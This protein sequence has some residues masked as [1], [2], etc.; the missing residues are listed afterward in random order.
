[1]QS[2]VDQSNIQHTFLLLLLLL[3]A[4]KAAYFST[5]AEVHY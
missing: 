3:L 5:S 4:S 1:M 2:K